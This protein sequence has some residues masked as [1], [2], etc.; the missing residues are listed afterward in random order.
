[1]DLIY[2]E[3]EIERFYDTRE[4]ISSVSDWGSDCSENCSTSFGDDRDVPES[5]GYGGWIRNLESVYERRNKF[6]QWMS[7]D[8]E[9]DNSDNKDE[10]EGVSFGR[11]YHDRILEDCGTVLRL[12]GSE[13]ELSSSFTMSSMSEGAPESS[14]NVSVEESYGYT[15]RNLDNG[16]EFI[17]DCFS[18]DGMLNMLREVGS[19]RSFSFDEFER[20][21]GQ[22]PLVQELF[23][24]N[25]EKARPI[26]NVRK[27]VKK[28]WLRKLGAVACIVDN[29][30]GAVKHDNLNSSS[31]AGMQQVRVHPYK[32]QAKDLSSL[33]VGQEFEAHK[34]PI[35]TMKFSFDGRYL[36]TAGEDRVVRVWQVIEDVKIDNFN[37]HNV[38]PSSMYFTTNHLSKLDPLDVKETVGK[39]KLKRSSS[40]ACVI[41]PPNLFRILEKPLH[42]FS[43]HSGEVLDLSWS[44]KGLLLSSSVDKTV[45]LWQL[46][47]DTCIRVYCHNNYVTC[48]SFN[49]LDE[50]HFIS[51]SID[52]KVRIWEVL[53]CQIVDYIDTREI[54]S[55]VCYRP[56]GK[57]GIVGSMTGNCRFYNIIDN[58]LELDTQIC[59][60]GKKKSPGKRII[61]FEFS[62]SDPSKLMVCSVD[63]PVHIISGGDIICKFKGPRNGGNKMSASFTS[64]GKHIVSA[65]EENIYVWNY[66]CKDKASRKKKIWSSESFFSHNASIAIPWSGVK[67]TPEPPVSPTRVCITA[68]SIPEMEPK[69]PNDDGD[70]EHK[71]PSS[72]PDCFSL[73]RNLF[74]ELLKG[75]ATWPAEKL[76]DSSSMTPSPSMCKTEFKFLKNAC[77]SMLSSPHMWGLV[78]VTAGWDGRI[79]TFLNYGLPVRL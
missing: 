48:V 60:N 53:A 40:T 78:I 10:E 15:I 36:A 18:Q 44:K 35:S 79:R 74:P 30:E 62:P 33:F 12:S 57:G 22:T 66:N 16:T 38:D 5:F 52:G 64:D 34:G 37:L 41:F 45:R 67:I 75:T 23:R 6:F 28:G 2:C 69:Y 7:L 56:D 9:L 29:R 14:G 32:K 68:E 54:V 1:M 71:V 72:S 26:V 59:L 51:G 8:L 31:K 63:S 73:S 50:N 25:V 55:A 27:E 17:V 21:I 61:G 47:C 4:E 65:S 77:Q 19:N 46:G 42:E 76:H 24:K 70:S 58:R 13:G 49:P 11:G 20:N 39:T 3:E 43:G